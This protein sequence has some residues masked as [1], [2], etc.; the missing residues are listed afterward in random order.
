MVPP[1]VKLVKDHFRPHHGSAGRQLSYRQVLKF[2]VLPS[3]V[4]AALVSTTGLLDQTSRSLILTVISIGATVLTALLAVVQAS[5]ARMEVKPSSGGA[6][7]V[8]RNRARLSLGAVR[9][10]NAEVSYTI[11]VLVVVI[12]V[13]ASSYVATFP[14]AIYRLVDGC[15]YFGA[16]TLCISLVQIVSDF[17]VLV[18]LQADTLEERLK[19]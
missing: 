4:A 14:C 6:D 16:A 17:Y 11:L 18:D 13:I 15:I 10:I 8:D 2:I 19:N 7:A 9:D 3:A 5:L 12:L 1:L